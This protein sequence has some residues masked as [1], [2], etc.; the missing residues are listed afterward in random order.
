MAYLRHYHGIYLEGLMKTEG[1][2][3]TANVLK[4]IRKTEHIPNTCLQHQ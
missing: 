3:T 4:K 1:T 2:V